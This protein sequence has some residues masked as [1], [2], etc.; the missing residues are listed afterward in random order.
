MN[1]ELSRLKKNLDGA[2]AALNS[3]I[4]NITIDS[5]LDRHIG[6]F[7]TKVNACATKIKDDRDE[8]NSLRKKK[9]ELDTVKNKNKDVQSQ[10]DTIKAKM[11]SIDVK[12]IADTQR[13]IE[14]LK[15]D[16]VYISKDVYSGLTSDIATLEK[17]IAESEQEMAIHQDKLN[18][19][20][21][22]KQT[23]GLSDL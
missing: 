1:Q 22:A 19:F 9:E 17:R 14:S 7:E 21:K 16:M 10:V 3:K 2:V 23:L 13:Y 6:G 18:R 11:M 5:I 12:N 4:D 8:L 15:Q 20:K